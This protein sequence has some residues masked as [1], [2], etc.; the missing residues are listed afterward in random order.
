MSTISSHVTA[1]ADCDGLP[2]RF[3]QVSR[4]QL[5]DRES[6]LVLQ[7]PQDIVNVK[8]E[9]GKDVVRERDSSEG[10]VW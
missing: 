1:F 7:L 8:G 6:A 10:K 4:E 9:L 2:T 3:P 5:D